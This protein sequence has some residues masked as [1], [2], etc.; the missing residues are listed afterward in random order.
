[1]KRRNRKIKQTTSKP[2]LQIKPHV[3]M[4]LDNESNDT[5]LHFG[6]FLLTKSVH[7]FE[8][9]SISKNNVGYWKETGST[10]ENTPIRPIQLNSLPYC[11]MS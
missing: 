4:L 9:E 10:N 6:H 2:T 3:P 11:C 1:M 5:I 7:N 8:F